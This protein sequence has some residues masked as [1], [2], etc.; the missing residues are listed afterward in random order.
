MTTQSSLT[1][2]SVQHLRER[3]AAE[4]VH[5]SDDDLEG[6]VAFL[7]TILPMLGQIEASLRPGDAVAGLFLPAED[8]T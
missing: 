1:T 7:D 4:G 2:P 5:P 3:C 6:V 8:G